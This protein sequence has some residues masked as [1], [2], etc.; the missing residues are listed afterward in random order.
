MPRVWPVPETRNLLHLI[1]DTHFG[2]ITSARSNKVL[3]DLSHELVPTPACHIQVGDTTDNGTSG[4]DTT[5]LAWLN[6]LDADWYAVCG[7]HDIWRD[8]RTVAAWA[9]AYG[10]ASKNYT[11]ELDFAKLIMVGPDSMGYPP[12]QAQITLA[13]GTLDFLEDEL[14][15]AKRDCIV[16][17]H[18]PLRDTVVGD[19]SLV[20]S[21]AETEFYV[22]PDTDIRA[23]L[24]ASRRAK[25]WVSGHTHSPITTSGFVTTAQCGNRNVVA[26]NASALYYT[27][28]SLQWNDP[29]VSLYM[30]Y[31]PTHVEVRFR[32]H[33]A[34]SWHGPDGDL[35]VMAA[36][37]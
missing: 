34:G 3:D 36:V 17:C 16:V 2:A 22:H 27:G 32:D 23:I 7:N 6:Q 1:G 18:A 8:G 33:G 10:Y 21:S 24:G 14:A 15:S 12:N 30:N 28:R 25:V 29:L 19:T 26:V 20:W 5:A 35:V 13:S 4:E 37:D 31:F 9:S 11:V